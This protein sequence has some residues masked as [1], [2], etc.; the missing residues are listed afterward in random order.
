M[1]SQTEKAARFIGLH[2]PGSPLLLPN[3]WDRGSAKLLASLG[4]QALATTSSGFAATLGRSDGSVSRDEALAHAA[5]IVAATDLPVSADL[6]NCFADDPGGVAQTVALAAATGLAAARSRTTPATTM[7]P[8]MTSGWRP[9]GSRPPSRP[10]MPGLPV[11]C[12]PPAPRTTCTGARTWRGRHPAAGVPGG[13]GRR[14]VRP[15]TD[16]PERHQAAGHRGGPSGERSRDA[17]HPARARACR[18]RGEPGLGR[19]RAGLRRP[20]GAGRR[21]QLS[22]ATREPTATSKAPQWEG[23]LSRACCSAGPARLPERGPSTRTTA[24]RP[25]QASAISSCGRDDSTVT[26]RRKACRS[27]GESLAS[28]RSSLA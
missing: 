7:S 11:S 19:R 15:R 5:A 20:R 17:R 25:A 16:S 21:R 14:A 6:E 22:S 26:A 23:A 2:R 8:F 13:G 4:F 28:T 1:T 24:L 27:A 12:S 10:R 18:G 9:S 3:P